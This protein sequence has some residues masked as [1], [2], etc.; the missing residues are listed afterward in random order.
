M[1]NPVYLT[2]KEMLAMLGVIALLT[3]IYFIFVKK[4]NAN[5]PRS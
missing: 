2:R 1:Q 5:K 3:L 4:V